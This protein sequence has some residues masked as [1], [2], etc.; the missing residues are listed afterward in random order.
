[1]DQR[2]TPTGPAND[3]REAAATEWFRMAGVGVEFIASVLVPTAAGYG[4]DRWLGT[5]P[6][7]LLAGVGLGFAVGLL[8]M[9]RS[10][11]RMFHD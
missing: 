10:A 3:R 9:V 4:L 7:L 2:P 6:W 1:M 8:A 11:K 5:S